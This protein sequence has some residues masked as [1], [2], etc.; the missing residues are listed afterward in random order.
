MAESMMST[1]NLEGGTSSS[2]V[3][4]KFI[5][6]DAHL[7]TINGTSQDIALS[8]TPLHLYLLS[9]TIANTMTASSSNHTD[10]MQTAYQ[11]FIY[12]GSA[13]VTECGAKYHAS[14]NY[15]EFYS[16]RT[17][18]HITYLGIPA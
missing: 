7:L 9:C 4:T 12:A 2:D 8:F 3:I 10:L 11:T 6:V 5:I 15:I 13:T 17:D 16:I 18:M 14:G 1:P